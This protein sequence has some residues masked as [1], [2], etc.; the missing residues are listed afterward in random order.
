[1]DGTELSELL[2]NGNSSS[3]VRLILHP[4]CVFHQNIVLLFKQSNVYKKNLKNW[5]TDFSKLGEPGLF[6]I[7]KGTGGLRQTVLQ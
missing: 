2:Y 3:T 7:T 1:M 6:L 4:L 5:N